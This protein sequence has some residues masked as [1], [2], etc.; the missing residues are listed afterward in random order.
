MFERY[1]ESARRTLFFS[2]YEASQFGNL[3]IEP[4]HLLLGLVRE[5]KGVVRKIFVA[6]ASLETIR[7][8]LERRMTAKEKVST[9]VELPFGSPTKLIL[10]YC[11]EE[12][13]RLKSREIRP[14]HLLLGILREERSLAA[15]VLREH[16]L[17]IDAVR[18]Q[19]VKY[20][21]DT[22]DED[23]GLGTI[24]Q[25]KQLVHLLADAERVEDKHALVV[26]II[27]SLDDLRR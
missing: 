3:S 17:S 20:S 14:E 21:A 27:A 6:P 24:A 22:S 5:G 7:V 10:N 12:A 25:I 13:D 8:A 1:T 15:S 4:E 11:A 26:Q 16:G 23:S 9:S 18:E 2:R 19:V